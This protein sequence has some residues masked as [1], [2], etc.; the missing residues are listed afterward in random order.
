MMYSLDSNLVQQLIEKSS[1]GL[2]IIAGNG[3]L[4][5]VN[6]A[7]QRMLTLVGNPIGRLASEA[8]VTA[9]LQTLLHTPQGQT[10]ECEIQSG[11]TDIFVRIVPLEPAGKLIFLEDITQAK[12]VEKTQKDFVANVSHELRTPATSISGY[13]Q[14]LLED[15]HVFQ[16]DHRMMIDAIHRNS[17]RLQAL[18]EDLLILSKIEANDAPLE[19]QELNLLGIV[20]ECVDKQT[21]RAKAENIQFNIIVSEQ[22]QVYSNRDALIHIIGNLVENAVK[23][24]YANG[25]VT[26]RASL[27]DAF[28][29]LEVIDLGMGIA[30]MHQQRIFERFFRVDKGRTRQIAGTGLGLAIVKTLLDRT[31]IRIELRSQVD[32][33]SIFRIYL[34]PTVD[35]VGM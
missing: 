22:L 13:A 11:N 26:V 32:K 19:N 29:Q 5:L 23:Y 14:M 8:I 27:R 24:S 4:Q 28:I 31:G 9:E 2:V 35:S 12:R 3:N 30:P 1:S 17:Q 20:Q 7:A 21:A 25:L 16:E 34:P 15:A 10:V 6:P 33:G 18:F